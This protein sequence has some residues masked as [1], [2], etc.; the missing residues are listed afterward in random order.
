MN[1]IDTLQRAL[2]NVNATIA[3][4]N[5]RITEYHT[6]NYECSKLKAELEAGIAKLQA[7]ER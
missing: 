7:D 6:Q 3:S 5:L 4:N 1:D 2:D